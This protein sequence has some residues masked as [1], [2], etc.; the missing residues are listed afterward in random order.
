MTMNARS[1]TGNQKQANA[2]FARPVI[3]ICNHNEI[4]CCT[5]FH[6]KL[7]GAGQPHTARG[8]FCTTL[9]LT[10]VVPWPLFQRKYDQS[11]TI[12]NFREQTLLLILG[13]R[14]H[15]GRGPDYG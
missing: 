5:A 1:I 11:A 2:L 12:G 14:V 4:G 3:D 15:Q 6:D 13:A 8:Q 9:Y 10:G 7:F